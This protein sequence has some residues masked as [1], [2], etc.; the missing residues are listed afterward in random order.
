MRFFLSVFLFVSL[1]TNVATAQRT[2]DHA[3][4]LI[5]D[6]SGSMWAQLPEGRSRIEVARDVLDDFLGARPDSVPLGV[7]AYGNNRKGDCTDISVIAPV[8][9]QD[10][11]ELGARLR[12]LS[13]RGKTPIADAL[14][15]A[16]TQI[17]ATSEDVDIVLITDGLETCGGDP[18]AVAA[19][20]AQSGISLR[21]HVV[22][23]GMTEGEIEQIACVARETGGRVLAARSGADLADALAK[24]TTPPP[25]AVQTPG[26]AAINLTIRADNA[27]RPEQVTFRAVSETT[28]ETVEFGVLDF[29]LAD[30]LAV[31]LAEGTWLITADAG[32]FGNGELVAAIVAGD[33]TT[34]YVPFRGLLPSLD[35][36]APGGAFRAGINGLIPYRI[37]QEGLATG[38]GDFVFTLLPADATDTA[39]RVIDY[40]TQASR[41]GSYVGAFRAPQQPGTYILAF[42]RQGQM[43]V[44]SVMKRFVVTVEDRPQVTLTAPPAAEP[45]APV[46]VTVSGG[47][48]NYDRVEIWR[49]GALYSW[50]QSVYMQE[51]FDNAYG[52][53]K[54][55]LAP[56]EPGNY[57]IVYLFSELYDEDSIAARAPLIVGDV[58]AFDEEAGISAP[59]QP[60]QQAAAARCDDSTGCAMGEDAQEPGSGVV[61]VVVAAEGAEAQ[62]VEWTLLPLNPPDE[63]AIASGGPIIGPWTT[64]LDEGT[65]GVNGIGRDAT[66]FAEIRVQAGGNVYFPIPRLQPGDADLSGAA[67]DTTGFVCDEPGNCVYEDT[68]AHI[69]SVIPYGWVTDIPVR[70]GYVAGGDRGLVRLVLHHPSR[71]DE[72]IVLNPRQ[73]ID[74][75]GPCVDVQAG[76]LC[77]FTPAGPETLAGFDLIRRSLRDTAPRNSPSP[78][79]ALQESLEGIAADD[80]TA[81]ALIKGLIGVAAGAGT[82][83]RGA[84][85]PVPGAR[86]SAGQFDQLRQQL[87]GN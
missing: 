43:P 8:Q 51:F 65:W 60:V 29:S 78:A 42:H 40:A 32:Q 61:Q 68:A 62:A 49:D 48:G 52:P 11:G 25:A 23:F 87:T 82:Q 53:A 35:M 71:P 24:T 30:S 45:G 5:L 34:L 83:G 69:L 67:T 21:A 7:I 33:N 66:F 59:D 14:R 76:Q 46:A 70:E 63:T 13:P 72:A 3:T 54:P 19:E 41:L 44:D 50:D 85:L 55:L 16:A 36:P 22:G 20:L 79:E 86:L 38:G 57:E 10:G 18:C 84:A 64:R 73:W 26:V 9:P 80:P 74:Q 2:D 39:D 28:G 1:W 17:P 75:N 6:A 12:A 37:T 4:I 27:G 56:S 31:R 47:M 77:H 15:L 58:P 81:A